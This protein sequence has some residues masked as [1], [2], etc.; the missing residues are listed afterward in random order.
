MNP[1]NY[2]SIS[3]PSFGIEVNPPRTLSIGPFTAH[4]YGLVI[5]VGLILAVLY[6]C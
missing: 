4:Y 6:A 1:S 5:A 2:T 3:F